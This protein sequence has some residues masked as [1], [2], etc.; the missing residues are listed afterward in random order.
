M[1]PRDASMQDHRSVRFCDSHVR[2]GH[3]WFTHGP[4]EFA[5]SLRRVHIGSGMGI[6]LRIDRIIMGQFIAARVLSGAPVP[7]SARDVPGD[8]I[9]QEDGVIE[10]F[11]DNRIAKDECF[12]VRITNLDANHRMF[13]AS[14]LFKVCDP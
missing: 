7:D 4:V 11:G 2:P 12:A 9:Y 8:C 3:Q 1:K 13:N 5:G 6:Y 10:I 14:V